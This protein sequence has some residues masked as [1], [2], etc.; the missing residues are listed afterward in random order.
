MNLIKFKDNIRPGDAYFNTYLKDQYAYWVRMRYVI[1][2]SVI[3]ISDYVSLER[4]IDLLKTLDPIYWDLEDPGDMKAYIDEV[5][6]NKINDPKTYEHHNRYVCDPDITTD[7]VKKFRTWLAQQ[8]LQNR[9]NDWK[10]ERVFKYY[11]GGMM[12]DTVRWFAESAAQ[13]A[14]P[15]GNLQPTNPITTT[16]CGC[17]QVSTQNSNSLRVCDPLLIY[18]ESIRNQMMA[19]FSDLYFWLGLPLPLLKEIKIYLDHIT[20][21]GLQLRKTDDRF[22][23]CCDKN[24]NKIN[25]EGVSKAFEYM[26]LDEVNG[27]KNFIAGQLRTLAN[28]YEWLYWA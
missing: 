15:T 26:I 25:L 5:E 1:P 21:L 8:L 16:P 3:S 19:L 23:D 12:D 27:N 4:D 10:E 20:R 22:I 9:T 11:V 2:M 14:G 24:S 18:R 17:G 13:L 6:T 7:E 28:V